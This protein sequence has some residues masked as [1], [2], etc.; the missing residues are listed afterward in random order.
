MKT[1][2]KPGKTGFLY[3]ILFKQLWEESPIHPWEWDSFP[4]MF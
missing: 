2:K 4:Y 1:I 3:V